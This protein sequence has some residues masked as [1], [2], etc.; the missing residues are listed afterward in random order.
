MKQALLHLGVAFRLQY[1]PLTLQRGAVGSND[2]GSSGHDA[3]A[4][5]CKQI[6]QGSK[7]GPHPSNPRQERGAE[8]GW[9]FAPSLIVKLNCA[10]RRK[11]GVAISPRH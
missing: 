1:F 4:V 2:P 8:T 10:K 7:L 5:V 6:F 11:L 9:A 3:R